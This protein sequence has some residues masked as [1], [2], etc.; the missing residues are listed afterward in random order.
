M[1]RTRDRGPGRKRGGGVS[2]FAAV[3]ISVAWDVT[4]SAKRSW[5]LRVLS[6]RSATSGTSAGSRAL[7]AINGHFQRACPP[8]PPSRFPPRRPRGWI[9][10]VG[11]GER[12]PRGMGP[13]VTR[14]RAPVT[15]YIMA[16]RCCCKTPKQTPL[17]G[18]YRRRCASR[19]TTIPAH[20]SSCPRPAL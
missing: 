20:V 16:P 17:F 1:E 2:L 15:L 14:Q 9:I 19:E 18:E 3:F 10:P 8:Q 7:P 6:R 13:R 12:Q 5:K 4:L 11:A